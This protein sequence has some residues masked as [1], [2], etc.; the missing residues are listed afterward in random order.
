MSSGKDLSAEPRQL[1]LYMFLNIHKT[2]TS[3]YDEDFPRIT[4]LKKTIKLSA[5]RSLIN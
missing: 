3:W 5:Y 2:S 4:I 1:Q